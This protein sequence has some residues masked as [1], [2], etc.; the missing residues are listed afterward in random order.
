[1]ILMSVYELHR[2]ADFWESP[3]EFIPER[4]N[5]DNR[6]ELQDY[7]CPFGAGPR[8]CVGNNFAMYEMIMTVAEIIKKYNLQT[9]LNE[10]EI[11]PLISLKPRTVPIKFVER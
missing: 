10:V 5:T 3:N 1:M 4:F 7:Y 11:N 8:M 2:H 6:K 9:N